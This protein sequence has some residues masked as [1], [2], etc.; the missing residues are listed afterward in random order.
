MRLI[1]Y[2]FSGALCLLLFLAGIGYTQ[3]VSVY[4][5]NGQLVGPVR[6]AGELLAVIVKDSAG[7]PVP[8]VGVYWNVTS[9]GGT[10]SVAAD[11]V[12]G[13]TVTNPAGIAYATFY[14]GADPTTFGLAWSQS[15][16]TAQTYLGYNYVQ[17]TFTEVTYGIT[18]LGLPTVA[19][20]VNPVPGVI[21][22]SGPAGQPVGNIAVS[23]TP[24]GYYTG[25]NGVPGVGVHLIPGS[26]VTGAP[27]AACAGGTV[28]TTVDG[29]ANCAVT[30]SGRGQGQ[31]TLRVGGAYDWS[32]YN[33]NVTAGPLA[34]IRIISGNN[35][36]ANVGQAFPGP[37][38]ARGEDVSGGLPIPEKLT[39]EPVVA[40]TVSLSAG[41]GSYFTPSTSVTVD[42]DVNGRGSVYAMPSVAGAIQVRVRNAS[43]TIQALFNLTGNVIVSTFQKLSG[44]AQSAVVNTDFQPLV[45][46]AN[47][48]SG[49]PVSGMQVQWSASGGVTLPSATST[50]NSQGQASV[51]PHAG[52]ATGQ[53]TVTATAGTFSLTF[54]L[55]VRLAGPSCTPSSFQNANYFDAG[56]PT[57]TISPGSIATIQCAGL[58]PGIQ[59]AVIPNLMVGKLPTTVAGV[60]VMFGGVAA[61]IFGVANIGGVERVTVQVPFETGLGNASVTVKVGDASASLSVPIVAASPGIF[62]AAMSDGRRRAVA[63]HEDGTFVSLESPARRGEKIR[64]FAQGLGPTTPTTI[65]TNQVGPESGDLSVLAPIV[66][67]VNNAGVRVI[68]A[69]YSSDLI[70]VYVVEFEMPVDTLPGSNA[71]FAIGIPISDVTMLFGNPS[72]IPVQ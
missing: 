30:L 18:S 6:Q 67:G 2:R 54:N 61:P 17:T 70:G 62:E 47:D 26:T 9:G 28:L 39:F 66:V 8:S 12:T 43:G 40:G 10:V 69:T 58:A 59:G 5:G 46:Q 11:P 4:Q 36:T 23:V 16:V 21:T 25:Y 37:L 1:K 34:V 51:V 31:F 48:N 60:T 71:P 53:A 68:S 32:P 15:T 22:F 3:T 19:V 42:P 64:F 33:F 55:V 72:M 7:N 44:D 14:G 35:Q 13:L 29:N 24:V 45:V 41:G 20:Q 49:N 57:S 56:I 52:S 27:Q 50:T 38:V 63:V 65:G